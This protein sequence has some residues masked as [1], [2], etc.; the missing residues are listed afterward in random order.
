MVPGRA[1]T[2]FHQALMEHSSGDRI[3]DVYT[4]KWDTAI[5]SGACGVVRT[6]THRKTNAVFALK[7]IRLDRLSES[8]APVS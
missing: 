3:G 2:K 6:C 8:V 5:G 7:T 4:I 1:A